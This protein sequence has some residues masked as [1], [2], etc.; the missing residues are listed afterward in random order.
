M[1]GPDRDCRKLQRKC[2]ELEVKKWQQ[3]ENN[4]E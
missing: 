2:K 4:D 3:N 1:E